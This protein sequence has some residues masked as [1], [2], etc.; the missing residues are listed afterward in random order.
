MANRLSIFEFVSNKN[1]DDYIA[2][3]LRDFA[4]MEALDPSRLQG[5]NRT[6][7][8]Q[9]GMELLTNL[10]KALDIRPL[11]NFER[12]IQP[13]Y[14]KIQDFVSKAG[15]ELEPE[16]HDVEFLLAHAYPAYFQDRTDLLQSGQLA[17]DNAAIMPMDPSVPA[18]GESIDADSLPPISQRVSAAKRNQQFNSTLGLDNIKNTFGSPEANKINVP[19]RKQ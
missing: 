1:I 4:L 16:F 15:K 17:N 5:Y 13:S 2:E 7:V 18:P 11:P 10:R 6:R 19:V 8:I 14:I 3:F 12:D 9:Q